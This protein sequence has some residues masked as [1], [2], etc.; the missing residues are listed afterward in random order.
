MNEA[1]PCHAA[2]GRQSL[3]S[4]ALRT[5]ASTTPWALDA[6]WLSHRRPGARRQRPTCPRLTAHVPGRTLP[7]RAAR[8]DQ[9]SMTEPPAAGSTPAK[10]RRARALGGNVL[11]A[12]VTST[13]FLG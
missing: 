1:S 5:P 10:S 6:P 7:L 11:L 9:R 8:N 4:I 12:V 3:Y 13:V 2:R